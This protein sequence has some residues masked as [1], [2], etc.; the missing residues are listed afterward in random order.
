MACT[1]VW[2]LSEGRTRIGYGSRATVASIAAA[3]KEAGCLRRR[4][5][6]LYQTSQTHV[7]FDVHLLARSST[8]T[9]L[10]A[11]LHAVDATLPLLSQ[12]TAAARLQTRPR[13]G[14]ATSCRP[15]LRAQH[16]PRTSVVQER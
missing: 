6:A 15:T 13:G 4:A 10:A 1:L 9:Q 3:G 7:A 12:L 16:R 2:G 14:G 11:R 5:R 8:R